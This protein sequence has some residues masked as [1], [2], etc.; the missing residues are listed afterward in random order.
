VPASV[1]TAETTV[2]QEVFGKGEQTF[3]VHVKVFITAFTIV[4]L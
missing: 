2:Q 1:S 4:I 3:L